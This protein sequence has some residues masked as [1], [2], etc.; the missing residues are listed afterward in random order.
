MKW[1]QRDEIKMPSVKYVDSVDGPHNGSKSLNTV[2]AEV[3]VALSPIAVFF[4]VF[5]CPFGA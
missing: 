1:E 5:H 3:Y 4:L 2:D